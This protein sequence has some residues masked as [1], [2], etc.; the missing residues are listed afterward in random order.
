MDKKKLKKLL[1]DLPK[2]PGV[3]LMKDARGKVVYVG[4]AKNLSSRVR[5]Y[6]AP[7]SS[8]TRF[9]S[10]NIHRYVH[11][12]ETMLTTTEKEA[13]LLENSLIKHHAP[14]FN[15]QL[16]DDKNYLCL[17]LDRS[18]KWPK[19]EVVRRPKKDGA[20]YFGPYHSATAARE[21]LKLV[22][23][24]FKIRSCKNREMANR[25]RPCLQHQIH[26]CLGPCVLDVNHEE[27]MEQVEYVRL[28]LL[29]RRDELVNELK[30]H[31]EE[32][33]RALQYE[34]AAVLR[35]QIKA[36]D[37]TLSPQQ[38]VTP[39]GID[40]DILGFHRQGDQIQIVVLE[41]RKGILRAKRDFYFSGQEFPDEEILSSFVV[42]R[43]NEM[44]RIPREVVV[45][46]GLDDAAALSEILSDRRGK[47]ARVVH[48]QRGA[49]FSKTQMADLNARQL[50]KVRLQESDAIEK[51]LAAIQRRLR[52]SQIPRRMECVDISHL[53]GRITVGAVSAVVDGQVQ[54]SLGKTYRIKTP[55]HG[56]DYGAM[57]E[58]LTRR[59]TRARNREKGWE[60]PDLLVVDGGRGQLAVACAVLKELDI[61]SQP[62]VA[63]AKQRVEQEGAESDRVFIPG[64]KNPIPLKARV[65]SLHMLAMARDEAHRLAIT[66]QRKL[67]RKKTLKSELDTIPGVGPKIKKALLRKIG[68]V[69]KIKKSS[70][71]DLCDVPGIGLS[72]AQNIKETLND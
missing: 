42:Q 5:S 62:V 7:G 53:A 72:L 35:D 67:R 26:R 27:Y 68:S 63:L 37:V 18:H 11:G 33:A 71:E 3:Y 17:R 66:Y 8:D 61:D 6:F 21:T 1:A 65:S 34:K 59:F 22:R 12:I 56:D 28:F 49:R 54:R 43:Y 16:R 69:K 38:V 55:V 30:A 50:L 46:K 23:R 25:V 40:Q 31:M 14:R 19:L 45:S 39:G 70:I 15:I 58:L 24:H 52:L 2:T 60:A 44:E 29:G 41:V 64:R 48:P 36:V 9:F 47:K 57:K 32:A 10:R 13:L 4:K 51:N 20:F